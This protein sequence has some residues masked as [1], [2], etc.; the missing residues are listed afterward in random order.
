MLLLAT[1]LLPSQSRNSWTLLQHPTW[2]QT[3]LRSAL[4]SFAG[5][6]INYCIK[7]KKKPFY[8]H[9][10]PEEQ[11]GWIKL[12]YLLKQAICLSSVTPGREEYFHT[13]SL[14]SLSF[15]RFQADFSWSTLIHNDR[16]LAILSQFINSR[17]RAAHQQR[18][19]TGQGQSPGRSS[20][21]QV[22]WRFSPLSHPMHWWPRVGTRQP[23]P[24]LE[25]QLR[26]SGA[27]QRLPACCCPSHLLC[28][29]AGRVGWFAS[30]LCTQGQTHKGGGNTKTSWG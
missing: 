15:L 30:V 19:L 13:S 8:R 5:W 29:E 24:S 14:S 1:L 12:R 27:R 26:L 7:E 18:H 23:H 4:K 25:A 11:P 21:S 17:A 6:Q 9:Y 2:E 10:F 16:T 3:V 22:P 20:H 28:P